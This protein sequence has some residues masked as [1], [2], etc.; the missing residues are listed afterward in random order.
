[1][2]VKVSIVVADS[3]CQEALDLIVGSRLLLIDEPEFEQVEEHPEDK[4]APLIDAEPRVVDPERPELDSDRG[5]VL[6]LVMP[7]R[8]AV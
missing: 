3:Q 5:R 2:A 6:L 1:M 4:L 8:E 7:Q